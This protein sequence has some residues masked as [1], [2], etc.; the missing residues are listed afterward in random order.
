[1]WQKLVD[2]MYNCYY[3]ETGSIKVG[4]SQKNLTNITFER[5]LS[6]KKSEITYLLQ[7]IACHIYMKLCQNKERL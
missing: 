3:I 1:M 2:Q 5:T 4:N 7:M 6:R